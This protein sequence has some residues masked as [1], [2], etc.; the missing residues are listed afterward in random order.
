MAMSRTSY[1]ICILS[2]TFPMTIQP[3]C[4][5]QASVRDYLLDQRRCTD[6]CFQ[7]DEQQAHAELA[8]RCLAVLNN[9]LLNDLCDLRMPDAT[10][11][12]VGTDVKARVTS[13]DRRPM[14]TDRRLLYQQC[15]IG[16]PIRT[17]PFPLRTRPAMYPLVLIREKCFVQ[18]TIWVVSYHLVSPILNRV[19][20][21]VVI[22]DI[23]ATGVI[24]AI[25]APRAGLPASHRE[26]Q[27]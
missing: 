10:T 24:W 18:I 2:S 23:G 15:K 21:V 16:V 8:S 12:D 7:I 14:S 26:L 6:S 27:G 19:V 13:T 20:I 1:T 3:I 11:L 4:P 22:L 25:C 5:Q 9:N 17:R